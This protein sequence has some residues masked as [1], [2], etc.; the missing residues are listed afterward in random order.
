[1]MEECEEVDEGRVTLTCVRKLEPAAC[2]N[3][4]NIPGIGHGGIRMRMA[5]WSWWSCVGMCFH[6][7]V[8]GYEPGVTILKKINLY[9]KPGQKIAF[10]GT[11]G[12]GKTTITNLINRFY[13]IESGSITYDGIDVKLIHKDDLRWFYIHCFAGYAPVHRYNSG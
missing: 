1:M 4:R 7:V 3:V 9:A 5:V 8:F 13:D 11:S 12:A 2:R 6:D 10:V